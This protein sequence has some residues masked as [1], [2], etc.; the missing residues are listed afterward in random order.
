VQGVRGHPLV[1]SA[2]AVQAVLRAPGT[3]GGVGIR[4]WLQARGQERAQ[5]VAFLPC[6][7]PGYVSDLDTPEDLAALRHALP[8]VEIAWER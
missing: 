4:A 6:T 5:A 2:A 8:G 3:A 7:S 1:L